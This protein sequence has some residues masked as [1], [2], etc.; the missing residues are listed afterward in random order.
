M[1]VL[2]G[3]PQGLHILVTGRDAPEGILRMADLVT[4]MREVRH[5]YKAGIEAQKGIE[6]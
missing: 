6:W 1:E 4:E 3:R 5:P 2:S